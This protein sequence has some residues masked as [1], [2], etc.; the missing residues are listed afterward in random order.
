MRYKTVTTIIIVM[1][2]VTG[3]MVGGIIVGRHYV[4]S[5]I[6]VIEEYD[7]DLAGQPARVSCNLTVWSE[8]NGEFVYE[9]EEGE[10]IVFTGEIC[11]YPEYYSYYEISDGNWV[12]V[13]KGKKGWRYLQRPD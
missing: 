2:V 6:G 12:G 8:P 4:P 7:G 9:L 1:I 10:C 13:I 5:M 3:A 11:T